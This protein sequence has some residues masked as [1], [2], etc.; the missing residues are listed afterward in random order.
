MAKPPYFPLYANDWLSSTKIAMMRPEHEGAYIRLLAYAWNDSNC[1]LP[2]DDSQLAVLSRLNEGWFNGG[3]LVVR[4]CF[5]PHP[6]LVGRLINKRLFEERK[7]YDDWVEKSRQ[8]GRKSGETRR[9]TKTKRR[10]KGGSTV[11]EP[12]ANQP[13]NHQY[14]GEGLS[15]S[16]ISSSGGIQ[17]GDEE[18]KKARVTW[19]TPFFELWERKLGGRMRAGQAATELRP[20]VE[21]HTEAIV[22][23]HLE[24]YLDATEPRFVSLSKFAETFGTWNG[25]PHQRSLMETR[26]NSGRVQAPDGKYENVGRKIS[27]FDAQKEPEAGAPHAT[28]EDDRPGR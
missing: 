24:A 25:R 15:S 10:V 4:E 28:P 5:E 16:P 1:S 12:K 3:S 11:V 23:K 8:G 18:K 9:L 27:L 19:L 17:G 22:L 21:Q 2:D 14:E 26:A 7:K 6:T 13:P 20:L